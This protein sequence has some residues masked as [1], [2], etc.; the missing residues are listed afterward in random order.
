MGRSVSPED[1]DPGDFV[2]SAFDEG[3]EFYEL[4]HD[5]RQGLVNGLAATLYHLFEQQLCEFYR[6]VAWD[7]KAVLSGKDAEEKLR[8][9]GVDVANFPE[10]AF[11]N[12]LCLLT[13]CV[14]HAEGSFVQTAS[15]PP[16]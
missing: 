13:N 10:W 11:L 3:F 16:P 7:K 12:E 4:M 6:L 8:A 9:I 1:Y 14:K 2:D 15:R 5:T